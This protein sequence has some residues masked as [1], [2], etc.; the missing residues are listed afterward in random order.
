MTAGRGPSAPR[1]VLL[2]I[3]QGPCELLPISSSAHTTLVPWLLGCDDGATDPELRKALEVALHAGTA[4]ALLAAMR[5]EV[6]EAALELDGRRV[7]LIILSFLPP[8]VAGLRFERQIERR[9]GTPATIA[10]GLLAGS[11]AM[12]WADR[13]PG[14]RTHE[15]AGALDGL[16][17]GLAQTAALLP[18]VSRNGATL[19]AARWR[20]F[21]RRDAERLSR[22]VALPVIVGAATLKGARLLGRGTD[23]ATLGMLAAGAGA[24]AV[25]TLLAVRRLGGPERD[26]R[27]LPFALYRASLAAVTLRRLR[28]GRWAPGRRGRGTLRSAPASTIGP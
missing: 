8:A 19:A 2:G 5:E 11:A 9:F 16:C 21:A 14:H 26:R 22:H 4:V 23:G 28:R 25:S 15:Q 18:G 20:G 1:A 6:T 13:C 12:A 24:A 17:L 10:W 27:L 7:S 3:L